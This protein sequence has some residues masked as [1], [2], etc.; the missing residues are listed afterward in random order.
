MGGRS[1]SAAIRNGA[2]PADDKTHLS[3]AA[4]LVLGLATNLANPK[5]AIVLVGMTA[6][7]ADEVPETGPLIL[8]VLA[9]PLLTLAWFS[10]LATVLASSVICDRL[11]RRQK[12]LGV[13]MGAALVGIGVLLIQTAGT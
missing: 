5:A 7:M 11:L 13:A 10:L 4:P 1:L 6:L 9:M 3:S 2:G 8:L 12:I